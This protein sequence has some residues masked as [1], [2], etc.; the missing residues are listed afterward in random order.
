MRILDL[1]CCQGGAAMGYHRAGFDVVGVDIDP[2]PR[3]PFEFHQGDALAYLLEHGHEFDAIHASPPCQ[4][5]TNAQKIRGNDHPDYVDATRS[6]IPEGIPYV[7]ENVPG[8][9]LRDPIELC[10]AMFGLRT[11]RHR[12]FESSLELDVPEHP[13]HV[14]RTTKMGRPPVAGEFMHVVGNFSGV[15]EAREAMGGIDWM[16][17]DGLRESIPPVYTEHIGRQVLAAL[18]SVRA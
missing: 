13:E 16:N 17:R 10:G 1:Y 6:L 4:A 11:Y 5:F 7:I 12:L 14:A 8:A 18:E 15:R 2:Q 9:P 3:Y